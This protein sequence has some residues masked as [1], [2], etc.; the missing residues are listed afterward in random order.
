MPD[1]NP[2]AERGQD[3]PEP[4]V[5]EAVRNLGLLIGMLLGLRQEALADASTRLAASALE[6][7][8]GYAYNIA[9]ALGIR[10]GD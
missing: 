4:N 1:A 7:A 8:L 3:G 9:Y 10:A 2:N 5:T 6:Q